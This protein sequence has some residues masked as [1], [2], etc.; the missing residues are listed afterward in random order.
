M[1]KFRDPLPDFNATFTHG[2]NNLATYERRRNPDPRKEAQ[3][4]WYNEQES[5]NVTKMIKSKA[6]YEKEKDY[7][8]SINDLKRFHKPNLD[9]GNR[10]FEDNLQLMSK[11]GV[12]Y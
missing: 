11:Y 1:K 2:C 6:V 10:F 12:G 9:D 8:R 5:S 3:N 4:S 7:A